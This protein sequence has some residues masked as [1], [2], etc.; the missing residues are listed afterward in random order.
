MLEERVLMMTDKF[1]LIP[2]RFPTSPLSKGTA[3]A[4]AEGPCA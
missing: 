3:A 1:W 4:K 2:D